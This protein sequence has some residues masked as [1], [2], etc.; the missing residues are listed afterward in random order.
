MATISSSKTD[1]PNKPSDNQGQGERL[2]NTNQ[3]GNESTDGLDALIQIAHSDQS[4][5]ALIAAVKQIHNLQA[6]LDLQTEAGKAGDKVKESARQQYFRI[7]GGCIDAGISDNDRLNFIRELPKQ[8]VL[9]IGLVAKCKAAGDHVL[10]KINLPEDLAEL[11]RCAASVHVRKNAV[12]KIHDK[13][14]LE[15]L[16]EQVR[17]KDKTVFKLIEQRLSETSDTDKAETEGKKTGQDKKSTSKKKTSNNKMPAAQAAN[18]PIADPAV[19]LPKLEAEFSKVSHK[20]TARLN[21]LRSASNNLRAAM[22]ESSEEIQQKAQKLHEGITEKLEKNKAHQEQLNQITEKLLGSLKQALEEGQ[23]HDAIPA[24]DKIQGNISN[25]SGK[26]R[27]SL[28]KQANAYKDKLNELRDWK[29][30]AATEKKKELIDHMQHLIESKMHAADRSKH[31][32][33]MHQEWKT[34]GRS[35]QNEELWRTFKKLSDQAYEPCKEYFKQRK[36]LMAS[37][38]K[39]RRELC[40]KLEHDLEELDA[41]NPNISSLNKLLSNVDK[42]WQQYAPI[43]QTKIKPLQKRFYA[44]IN[45]LRKIRKNALRNNGKKKQEFIAKAE[46]LA[47]LEDN[48]QAMSEA[49]RLQQDWKALGP[50]SFKEDKKYW[51][52]FRAACDKIFEKRNHESAELRENLQQVEQNIG[53]I[54]QSLEAIFALQDDEFRSSRNEYQD[55]AQQ[56][57]SALDPRIKKQRKRLLDHFNDLKRKID[58]RFKLL[59][60]KKRQLL[61]NALLKKAAFLKQ[62]EDKLLGSKDDEQFAESKNQLDDTAWEQLESSG[63]P[64]YENVLL[65]RLQKT[66]NADSLKDLQ[67]LTTECE[68]KARAL[69][70][71]LEILA[72]IDTPKEDQPLRMQIQLDQLKKG[73]G[74]S[75]PDRKENIKYAMDVELQSFCLGPLEEKIQQELSQRLDSA[76]KKLL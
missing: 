72:N 63:N 20:N 40:D 33:K 59:P 66:V 34:L 1:L 15:E 9:Q 55:L 52:S 60:D 11:S 61:K 69:C 39:K 62:L 65:E 58:D 23:S 17:D 71:E 10:S 70:I 41:E 44:A 64:Q 4:D 7:L 22:A 68:A 12:V 19:E 2:R 51:D 42:E 31:I 43:E 27:A 24:W 57:A 32:S 36:Q 35:S 50:T 38:L 56:F 53:K 76:I 8:S 26:L 13:K 25:T 28:Q 21:A 5:R 18:E 16:R 37:N 6:L 49:K 74:Q 29:I 46:E 47:M 3:P 48:Q 14:L 75:K 67:V 45:K 54:L 30:F 73:F